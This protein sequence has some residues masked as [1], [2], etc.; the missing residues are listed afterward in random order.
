MRQHLAGWLYLEGNP[1]VSGFSR[2]QPHKQGGVPGV[3]E[4]HDDQ[5]K[6]GLDMLYSHCAGT[7]VLVVCD[8]RNRFTQSIE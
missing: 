8:Y 5:V 6:T 7:R 3:S 2:M 1:E 4:R